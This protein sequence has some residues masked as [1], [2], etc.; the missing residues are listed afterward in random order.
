MVA[1]PIEDPKEVYKAVTNRWGVCDRHG[2]T[3]KWWAEF[4]FG[5]KMADMENKLTMQ[6][7]GEFLRICD[8]SGVAKDRELD[9]FRAMIALMVRYSEDPEKP[10][11][12][13][14]IVYWF[15]HVDTTTMLA[16]V[17]NRRR[18]ACSGGL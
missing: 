9:A 15:Q 6:E 3:N 7:W 2:K 4:F 18:A 16:P 12:M 13:S 17:L 8:E 14:R 5:S 10:V 1:D 11:E